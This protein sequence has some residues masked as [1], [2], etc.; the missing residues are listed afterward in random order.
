MRR[1][2]IAVSLFLAMATHAF[3]TDSA[4]DTRVRDAIHSETFHSLDQIAWTGAASGTG[5]KATGG[6]KTP[7]TKQKPK[8]KHH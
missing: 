4:Q 5:W 6:Y 2:A 7:Q 3:S 1:T 8:P